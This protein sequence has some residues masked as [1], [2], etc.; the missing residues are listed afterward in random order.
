[1]SMPLSSVFVAIAITALT[2]RQVVAEEPISTDVFEVVNELPGILMG[3]ELGKWDTVHEKAD[4]FLTIRLEDGDS[5]SSRVCV[6]LCHYVGHSLHAT[7]YSRTHQD[8]LAKQSFQEIIKLNDEILTGL[9]QLGEQDSELAGTINELRELLDTQF[10][11]E[12][13]LR[14]GK[15]HKSLGEYEDAIDAFRFVTRSRAT[16]DSRSTAHAGIAS[17]FA[18][19]GEHRLAEEEETRARTLAPNRNHADQD[20]STG[21][22]LG[23]GQEEI[24]QTRCISQLRTLRIEN[25]TNCLITVTVQIAGTSTTDEVPPGKVIRYSVESEEST[26]EISFDETLHDG[27]QPVSRHASDGMTVYFSVD[28]F[29]ITLYRY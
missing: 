8:Q 7:A 17:I 29:D 24:A 21:A 12:V 25:P 5:S 11:V 10:A 14:L 9:Q 15:L 16:A 3:M 2:S 19:K 13:G 27:H 1:M 23:D 28:D 4:I 6:A 22:V 20:D 26:F 18:A